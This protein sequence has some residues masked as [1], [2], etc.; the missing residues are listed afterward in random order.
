MSANLVHLMKIGSL[1]ETKFKQA[2]QPKPEIILKR[3]SIAETSTL[4]KSFCVE[5]SRLQQ[6]CSLSSVLFLYDVISEQY[7]ETTRI[8][9]ILPEDRLKP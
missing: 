7:L 4:T 8:S 9:N 1:A 6:L 5:K 3:K 2:N